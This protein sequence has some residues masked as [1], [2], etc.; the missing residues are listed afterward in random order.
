[1]RYLAVGFM[2]A[3]LIALFITFFALMAS[4]ADGNGG[5]GDCDGG[6]VGIGGSA[7]LVTYDAGNSIIGGVCVK[8]GNTALHDF[9]DT[10]V[11]T[12]CYNIVGIGTSVVTVTRLGEGRECQGLSHIDVLIV[13]TPIPTPTETPICLIPEG[14]EP[15]PTPTQAPT[16]PTPTP[17]ETP[18]ITPTSTGTPIPSDTLTPIPLIPSTPIPIVTPA[19]SGTFISP[20]PDDSLPILPVAFPDTGDAPADGDGF[21]W[22]FYAIVMGTAL[23]AVGAIGIA[24]TRATKHFF[25]DKGG[26]TQL[27]P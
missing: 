19:G 25:G 4:S 7:D 2:G 9:Y 6:V 21:P 23:G 10:D 20:T 13:S 22:Y 14:C 26:P 3:L 18:V 17:A 5:H 8:A 16:T 15:T 12:G 24:A 27:T 1:M 11:N